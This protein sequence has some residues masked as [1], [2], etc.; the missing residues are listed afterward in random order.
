MTPTRRTFLTSA[1][2]VTAGGL[3]PLPCSGAAGDDTSRLGRTKQ[4]RFAVNVE[5]WWPKLPFLQRLEQ[6]AKLGFPAVE[7][8]PWRNKDIPAVAET[9][10]KLK[11]DVAQFTAWGFRPGLND[12]KNHNRFVEEVE[13][14]CATAKKLNCRLM[15]VVGGDDIAG[16]TQAQMH[17]NIIA[18]LRK[19]APIAEKHHITLIL[20]PMN[21]RV[22]HKG[23][24]LYGSVP[25]VRIIKAVGSKNV[26]INWDLYHMQIS[27]GDL[28]GH[29]REGYAALGYA[30]IADHPGRNEPGT[31][32]I[33]Y[34]RVLRQL[35]DLGY[36]GY[37]GLELRPAKG[38]VE[39]ARAV[40]RAD[41]W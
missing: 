9:C 30:Q 8:W 33:H 25:T 21:I 38:E 18:G 35:H 10:Q 2:A 37:V 13:A 36:R 23:H 12:P 1:A 3:T 16:L 27:E 29:L 26:K 31:G 20:E 41:Q 17:E 4:T 6:A 39:A 24:C 32:E 15:T 34:P 14:S 28:C 22:D 40:H 5:M 7:F 11:L 19:A